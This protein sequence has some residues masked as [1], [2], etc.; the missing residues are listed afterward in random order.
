MEKYGQQ[1]AGG[2]SKKFGIYIISVF[3]ME[4]DTAL[5]TREISELAILTGKKNISAFIGQE[6]SASQEIVSTPEYEKYRSTIK[7][8]IN[9]YLDKIETEDVVKDYLSVED[10]YRLAETPCKIH[11][12]KTASLFS[13]LTSLRL[14]DILS[15]RWEEIVDFPAGG[16]CVHIVCK[17]TKTEDVIPISEEAL[18]LIG[19]SSDRF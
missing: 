6:M 11:V 7:T 17:K 15:L 5:K 8:N 9:D 18:E 13:C 2:F 16:K 1:C 10:L 12:L 19:Y 4:K 14:G 3:S